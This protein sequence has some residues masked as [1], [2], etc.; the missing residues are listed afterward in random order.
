MDEVKQLKVL[1][2]YL[3][4]FHRIPENDLWW[5]EGFTEWIAVKKAEKF[6]DGHNQP[7]VPLNIN[8]YNLLEKD[9]MRWQA[10]LMKKYGVDGMCIYHYWFKDGRRILEKP[11]E[12]LLKWRTIDMPFCF[13]WA[14]E[15][16]ARSWSKLRNKNVWMN[17]SEENTGHEDDNGILLEQVY[18]NKGQ[19][20][21]H[22]NYLKQFFHDERYIRIQGKPLFV[23]YR[24]ANIPCLIEMLECWNELAEKDGL[25]GIYIIGA[26]C[27]GNTRDCVDAELYHEPVWSKDRISLSHIKNNHGIDIWQYDEIW[28]H[29]LQVNPAS[30]TYVGGFV[31]Y[32]DTPRRGAEGNIIE[33]ETP[34]KFAHYLTKLMAKNAALGND[35]VFLNAWNE[36]GEGMYLEPDS[37]N[38]EKFLEAVRYAKKNYLT[39]V[40]EFLLKDT[41]KNN[42]KDS[43]AG[44]GV[45]ELRTCWD[46][47]LHYLK[48][49]DYWMLLRDNNI[50]VLRWLEKGG[51]KSVAIYGYGVLGKHLY[52]ELSAGNIEIEY[53]I[54]KQKGKLH[55]DTTIY[56]PSEALPQTALIIVTATYESNEIYR[57]LKEKGMKKIISLETI[58]YE[59]GLN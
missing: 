15:T 55:V 32:D 12:N 40:E 39:Y 50:S 21:E 54:D 22:F 1:A 46:R 3:P 5:G 25:Q 56:L 18:G 8:Y 16:W 17:T 14:N 42:E 37:R 27:N 29:I 28:N 51:Y 48:V 44:M 13:C 9:T 33:G 20:E 52:N 26:G 6:Y 45:E 23:I 35:F 59:S 47:E 7:R 36:W 43:T 38:G 11:A 57:K 24:T 2:M 41:E 34:E 53:I 10:D 30:K 58:L 31:G 19:W 49:L 4:Q